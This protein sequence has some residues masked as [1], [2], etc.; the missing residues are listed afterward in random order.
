VAEKKSKEKYIFYYNETEH[1]RKITKNTITANNYASYFIAPVVF[2]KLR[3]NL[4]FEI[5]K[6]I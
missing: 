3:E 2:K 1:S 4:I 5:S 6:I